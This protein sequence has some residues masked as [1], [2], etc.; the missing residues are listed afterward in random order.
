M[1]KPHV[2]VGIIGH[3]CHAHA[4]LAAAIAHTFAKNHT[5]HEVCVMDIPHELGISR[6]QLI[7]LAKE[8][9]PNVQLIVLNS[10]E[11]KLMTNDPLAIF[12]KLDLQAF[13]LTDE[14][15]KSLYRAEPP[16]MSYLEGLERSGI[17]KRR[18]WPKKQKHKKPR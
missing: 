6:E 11:E 10:G 4:T 8:K 7:A 14:L 15:R 9:Y 17:L 1:T 5:Q 12:Q 16:N 3:V 18:E 13:T 2:N